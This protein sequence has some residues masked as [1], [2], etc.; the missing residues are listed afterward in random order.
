MRVLDNSIFSAKE[1]AQEISEKTDSDVVQVIG[2]KFVLYKKNEK[3]PVIKL[4]K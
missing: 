3:E 1:A 2:T 4:S